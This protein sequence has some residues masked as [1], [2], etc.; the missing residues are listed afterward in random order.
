[1]ESGRSRGA[2]R[3]HLDPVAVDADRVGEARVAGVRPG[4]AEVGA[5]RGPRLRGGER[6]R[7]LRDAALVDVLAGGPQVGAAQRGAVG[8]GVEPLA[9]EVRRRG[10]DDQ[11]DDHR[12]QHGE[13]DDEDRGLAAFIPGGASSTS[14]YWPIGTVCEASRAKLGAR[15]PSTSGS[16]GR[17]TRVATRTVITEV[18]W[19][20]SWGYGVQLTVTVSGAPRSPWSASACRAA[21]SARALPERV[22]R[23]QRVGPAGRAGRAA[24]AEGA[25][26][27]L[28][29]AEHDPQ[30]RDQQ[31]DAEPGQLDQRAPPLL[32]PHRL[33]RH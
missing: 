33:P 1:M 10:V 27:H 14:W 24:D 25:L 32:P 22:V 16:S 9:L 17:S 18:P 11:R 6:E 21:C 7:V 8:E 29:D 3:P 12:D 20:Q 19:W 28:E 13:A 23:R 4:F 30:H 26:L 5:D 2:C 31:Q 15:P